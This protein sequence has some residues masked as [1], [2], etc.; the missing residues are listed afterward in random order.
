L[1]ERLTSEFTIVVDD[2]RRRVI[3]ASLTYDWL[4]RLPVTLTEDKAATEKRAVVGEVA[5]VLIDY[6]AASPSW[7]KVANRWRAGAFL[8]RSE[9]DAR[10]A[11]GG[12]D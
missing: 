1:K 9:Y 2:G 5:D 6:K 12:R 8:L 11:Q 10:V 4:S 3:V 7:H